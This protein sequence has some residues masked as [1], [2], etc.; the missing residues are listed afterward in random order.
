[1]ASKRRALV[2]GFGIS[3]LFVLATVIWMQGHFRLVEVTGVSM[4]P[5]FKTGDRR[6]ATNAYWLVGPIKEKDI[7]VIKTDDD[8]GYIIKRVYRTQ[9]REV[10]SRYTDGFHSIEQGPFIVPDDHLFVLG[11]NLPESEDSRV[12]GAFPIDHVLGKVIPISQDSIYRLFVGIVAVLLATFFL[13]AVLAFRA[14]MRR[15]EA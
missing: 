10:E 12:L 6:L 1:M 9:G 11:D 14:R 2:G 7:V 13:Y 4:E 3:L 5:T 8:Q 15:K